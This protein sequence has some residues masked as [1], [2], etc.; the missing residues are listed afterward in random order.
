MLTGRV[1]AALFVVSG[2]VTILS[3]ALPTPPAVDRAGVLVVGSLATAV[4]AVVWTLPWSQWRRS[5]SLWLVPVAFALI[6]GHNHVAAADPYRYSLFFVI[7]FALIGAFHPVGTAARFAPLLAVAYLTPLWTADR[8][9]TAAVASVAYAV[10]ICVVVAEAL[11]WSTGRLRAAQSELDRRRDEARFRLL[12]Q[13]S[14]DMTSILDADLVRR[15]VSPA[16]ERILG[17]GPEDLLGKHAAELD[18]PDDADRTRR[19]FANLAHRPGESDRFEGRVRHRN[20]W[21]R[22]L[23]VV[24]TNR[25][26]DPHV[27]GFVVNSR[28]VTDRKQAEARLAHLAFHD[29]LTGVAN[30][31]LFLDRLGQALERTPESEAVAVLLLDLDGFK[32]VND[33]LGHMTG[34]QLLIEAARRMSA[35]LRAEDLIA[36][37]GGDEFAILLEGPT[38]A[39]VARRVAERLATALAPPFAVDGQEAVVTAS[40]GI[41]VSSPG[42]TETSDLLRAAD[43]ALYRGKAA[44]KGSV[45]IFDPGQDESALVRL[46]RET[47]LRRALERDELR[48][49]YQPIVQLTT[50]AVVGVEALVRWQHPERGLVLPSEFIPLAEETGLI[51]PIGRWVRQEACRQVSVWQERYPKEVRLQFSTNLSVREFRQPDLVAHLTDTL[52]QSGLP[53]E[54][55]TLEITEST[56]IAVDPDVTVN[57]LSALKWLGVRLALDDFG[58]G[59]ASLTALKRFPIDELKVDLSFVAG[60]GRSADDTAIVRATVSVAQALEVAVTAEGVE[61]S[62]QLAHLQDLGCHRGQG[63]HFSPALAAEE[64]DALLR[65]EQHR[66]PGTSSLPSQ[67]LLAEWPSEPS[68]PTSRSSGSDPLLPDRPNRAPCSSYDTPPCAGC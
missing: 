22:W 12:V 63:H 26:D 27:G 33:S 19:F 51:L 67:E 64:F 42:F 39:G 66:R 32:V 44:G 55:L 59:Y 16:C 61:T 29:P 45:A 58:T 35:C 37:F 31:A 40:V 18:H 65:A 10:P 54:S 17:Y 49:A 56:A 47:A 21:M 50:G 8:V 15:Y 14:S 52:Q 13:N 7:A 30:R 6:V 5:A 3:S 1:A 4:G 48:V 36:R 41:A 9:S 28:D 53:P 68:A 34:D 43:V 2:L 60:L 38:D 20:G 23:E 11:S 62:E 57:T 25:L 46:H 24:A